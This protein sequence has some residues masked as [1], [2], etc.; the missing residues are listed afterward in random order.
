MTLSELNTYIVGTLEKSLGHRE[1]AATA[2]LMLE[3]CLGVSPTVM[4]T[5]GDRTIEPETEIRFKRMTQR[6][7]NGEPPQYVVG[8]A[9]FMGMDFKVTPATLIPRPETAELIDLIVDKESKRHGLKVLDV[10]SGSGC[11]SIALSR[12]L[13]FANVTGIDISPDAIEVAKQNAKELRARV[14]FFVD[15]ILKPSSNIP[16][17][18]DLIVSNPP[19]IAE[20]E[21]SDIEPR[22]KDYEP[23]IALFVPDDNPLLF[24]KAIIDLAQ[25]S[26]GR[27]NIY[28]EINPIYARQLEKFIQVNGYHVHLYK[29]S[30][31]NNRFIMATP[32][33]YN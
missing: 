22:V 2:R 11:I 33:A 3:D 31:M 7:V 6:I 29:D 28:F 23:S 24:Y 4:L 19:Y 26:V 10:G 5:R 16:N 13:P 25:T 27:P 12:A 17:D 14:D 20:K 18:L 15:D 8:K 32:E 21:R 1:A 9:R 30:Q